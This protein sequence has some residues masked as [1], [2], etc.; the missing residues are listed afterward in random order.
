MS[1]PTTTRPGRPVRSARCESV[2]SRFGVDLY[3]RDLDSS[4][5][6]SYGWGAALHELPLGPVRL[7]AQTDLWEEPS[8]REDLRHGNGWN[9]NAE[10]NW[11]FGRAGLGAQGRQQVGGILPRHAG[12]RRRLRSGRRDGDVVMMERARRIAVEQDERRPRR[13][14]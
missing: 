6:K 10:A 2:A 9:A 12:E 3:L 7:S 8:S 14:P 5:D 4:V 13:R 1:T 11:S